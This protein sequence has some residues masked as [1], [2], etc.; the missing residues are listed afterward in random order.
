MKPSLSQIQTNPQSLTK[1]YQQV[2]QLSEQICQPLA[3]EDYVIQTMPDVSPAKWHLAHTTWF[4][5]TFLLLPHLKDYN[6][7]HP[8]YGFLFNSYYEAIGQRHPRPHRGLLSRPTVQEVYQYRHY[9]DAAMEQLIA[10]QSGN[11]SVESL[12]TLGLHHEQQHQELLLTDLKHV[13]AC[14][15]LRPAY[16]EIASMSSHSGNDCTSEK[17]LDY[18][19][20]LYS[21]GFAGTGFAFDNEGPTHQ[22]YLQDYYLAA[23]L[24]TNGE[25]LEFMKAGGYEKAEYWLSEGWG[26]VQKEQWQAPLYWEQIEGRWW[27][28]TLM[29]MQPVNE[30]EPVCHVSFFEADAFARWA[31]KRLP[32]EAEWEVASAQVP[33]RGN[34]LNPSSVTTSQLHPIAAT[35]STRPDQLY[36]DVWE[37]TQSAYL[38]YPGFKAASGA[39]GEYNG[40]FMCNQMVLRGGSCATP[41]DHIRSTY[42]N[43]FPP[44]ARW[45]FSGI[46]LAQ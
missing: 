42:R 33:I 30:V 44:S 13:L 41:A 29:G 5:E 19:G 34:L 9:V 36:G 40:K 6:V 1:H 35:R 3:I 43:F 39:I 7:F 15:P 20:G 22:V 8:Q 45:Q 21:I 14:N 18:P 12:I 25:Y 16:R 46:R 4:F 38:P 31:G 23:H 17:W 37:W 26:L 11:E 27:T 2:R 24:V 10:D 32:T 28:M